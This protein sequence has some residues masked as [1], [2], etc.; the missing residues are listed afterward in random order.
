[1]H[2]RLHRKACLPRVF[3]S[4]VMKAET[5][6]VPELQGVSELILKQKYCR[7]SEGSASEVIARVAK[8]LAKDARQQVRFTSCM[9]AGF[10]PAGRVMRGVGGEA[11]LSGNLVNCFVQPVADS[12]FG[13]IHGQPGIFKAAEMS[14]E[15]LRMGGGVGYD[16]SE[17]RPR[18]ARVQG[19]GA[20]AS[21]PVTYIRFFGGISQTVIAADQRQAAQMAVLRCDHPDIFEFVN[22]KAPADLASMGLAG[23]DLAVANRVLN[24]NAEF[25]RSFNEMHSQL[26]HFNLSVAVTDKFMEAVENDD[27]F[28]LVHAVPPADAPVVQD[29]GGKYVYQTIKARD[30]WDRIMRNAWECAEPGVLFIDKVNSRNNLWSLE[31]IAA[32]NPC[33][34]QFLPANGACVLGSWNLTRFVSN[35]FTDLAS[36]EFGLFEKAVKSSVE[37]LDRVI[38]VTDWPHEIQRSEAMSKRRIGLGYFA[39]ADTFLMLR[40]RYGDAASVELA[41]KITQTL[42]LAAYEASVELAKKSEPF[43]FFSADDY[44]APG[45]FASTLPLELQKKIRK[46]GIRN[47][48][49]LSIAPTGSIALTFGNNAS[50]GCEPIFALDQERYILDQNNVRQKFAIENAAVMYARKLQ[51]SLDPNTCATAQ[52]L[53]IDAHLNVLEAIARHIDSAVSK[54]V[55]I[56]ESVTYEEFNSLYER[57]YQIG[58]KGLSTFRPNAAR[59][60]VIQAAQNCA[61]CDAGE[62]ELPN[63]G[64]III[65]RGGDHSDES[66]LS[67]DM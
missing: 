61:E 16:F 46:Y 53:D 36:F 40:M 9:H 22:A 64:R 33:G 6:F 51:I 44:L 20:K 14:A 2:V 28:D 8:G 60:A 39:L 3:W 7:D 58:L 56:A 32:C 42:A 12:I 26:S 17:I 4:G 31:T 18:G 5:N 13:S 66:Q 63:Q 24:S 30:L 37:L 59:G 50:S 41:E 1:M 47:S 43:P 65:T 11:G 15:T 49:L 55:Y 21:G 48:H 38:D 54:T 57:A 25:A 62:C 27:T 45:T 34:E 19:N 52:D 35:P 10:V 29:H 67:L 23:E